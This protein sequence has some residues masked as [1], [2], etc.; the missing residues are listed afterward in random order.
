M[1]SRIRPVRQPKPGTLAVLSLGLIL[2]LGL[3]PLAHATTLDDARDALLDGDFERARDSYGQVA[4][5][6]IAAVDRATAYEYKGVA[7]ERLGDLAGAL[8]SYRA[9]LEL[10]NAADA[11]AQESRV[12]Q[13]IR[14]LMQQLSP[15]APRNAEPASRWR[16]RLDVGQEWVMD[17][18]TADDGIG[19]SDR[20]LSVTALNLF[21]T[22]SGD[23]L[24]LNSRIDAAYLSPLSGVANDDQDA[25][26]WL[27][28][29]WLELQSLPGDAQLRVGRQIAPDYGSVGR[30]DG[31]RF[32]LP[33]RDRWRIGIAAGNPVVA[34]NY[35][36][37]AAQ[38]FVAANA[39]SKWFGDRLTLTPY[40]LVQ[41]AAGEIDRQSVG[42]TVRYRQGRW[43]W[44]GA[45]DYDWGFQ[46]LNLAL[47]H[48]QYRMSD[49]LAVFGRL[50]LGATPF[51]TTSNALIGERTDELD[52][53]AEQYRVGQL[54]TLARARTADTVDWSVGANL[55]LSSRWYATLGTRY[56]DRE[57]TAE[58]AGVVAL[59]R[60]QAFR[61]W[62]SLV[63]SSIF[64]SGDAWYL[65]YRADSAT[66]ETRHRVSAEWRVPVLRRW[67][68]APRLA[69]ELRDNPSLNADRQTI[70]PGLRVTGRF[71]RRYQLDLLFEHALEDELILAF[72]DAPV[73]GN[74]TRFE[75]ALRVSL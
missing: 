19:D 22:Y 32:E 39:R 10:L 29:G 53:L 34:P 8:A 60:E 74:R 43:Q 68:V 15:T 63:G 28:R 20:S 75:L 16:T 71:G 35:A 31:V 70:A 65:S 18:F 11:A 23:R 40:M 67:R 49:R 3:I 50:R 26:L 21:T 52:V 62:V 30:F 38:R 54:R 27:S 37:S 47:L 33:V 72:P 14:T 57:A 55:S 56:T 2:I 46:T 69:A 73:A 13:R 24:E 36:A 17:E 59:P 66:R 58:L 44:H 6:P 12:R 48:G 4:V 61:S 5:A 45:L 1:M 7:E 41:D 25:E 64:R 51:L 9:S 42:S